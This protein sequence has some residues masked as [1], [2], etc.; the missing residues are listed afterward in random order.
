V[1][2][3]AILKPGTTPDGRRR[4]VDPRVAE[5]RRIVTETTLDLIAEVGFEGT[6][7]EL[8]AERSGVSRTTI[9][10]HWPD[11]SVLYLEAFDPPSDQL[12]PP[13]P[14]G[15]VVR[16]LR[17]YI[18]HVADR[19]NDNRFAAALTAQIDKSRRD[20]AYRTA[21]L[22]YAVARNEHS[23]NIFRAGVEAGQLRSD[24][25][26]LH[27]TDLILSFLVYQR[28]IRHRVLDEQL[29]TILHRELI[30]R[31]SPRQPNDDSPSRRMEV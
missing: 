14:T 15:D 21:H 25:D 28:L 18:Q 19:L 7:V 24:L 11:P 17:D 2:D 29:V 26:P 16:D 10:R 13:R 12:R 20:P 4:R 5:T 22:Q 31:C 8:I 3:V 30:E 27:E 6:T 23:V 9:Y 1:D